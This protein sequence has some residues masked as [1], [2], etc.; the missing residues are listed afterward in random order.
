[1]HIVCGDITDVDVVNEKFII[2]TAE[3]SIIDMLNEK[4]NY[5]QLQNALNFFGFEKFEIEK[6]KKQATDEDNIKV[7][8]KYF[9]NEVIII[10]KK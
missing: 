1:M 2:K 6:S 9:N 3:Q 4:E 5:K 8:N 10:N 7:L